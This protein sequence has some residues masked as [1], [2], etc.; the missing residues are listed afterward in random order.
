MGILY[1]NI[2]DELVKNENDIMGIIAYSFYKKHKKEWIGHFISNNNKQPSPDELA[3]FYHTAKTN[4]NG[5]KEQAKATLSAYISSIDDEYS[6]NLQNIQESYQSE[7]VREL[8][9]K[10]PYFWVGVAQNI[11]ASTIFIFLVAA[12]YVGIRYLDKNPS[13]DL[14]SIFDTNLT[15]HP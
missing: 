6:S 10:K 8:K 13:K 11:I 1:N 7:L 5:Y 15:K 2:Y 12:V 14:A 4:L 9:E 3:N